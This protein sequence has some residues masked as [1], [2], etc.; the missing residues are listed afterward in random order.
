MRPLLA[1]LLASASV[2]AD[3]PPFVAA[4]KERQAKAKAFE[5]TLT[6]RKEWTGVTPIGSN[7]RKDFEGIG[8]AKLAVDGER[9]WYQV[10]VPQLTGMGD[11]IVRRRSEVAFDGRWHFMRIQTEV[12][13]GER[14]GQVS[15]MN[16]IHDVSQ[17]LVWDDTLDPLRWAYR[18]VGRDGL[19]STQVPTQ[20]AFP[21][22]AEVAATGREERIDGRRC[23]EVSRTFYRDSG[24]LGRENP[25]WLDAERG[26][27][28]KRVRHVTIDTTPHPVLVWTPCR[29]TTSASTLPRFEP[30]ATVT[31]DAFELRESIP[32]ERFVIRFPMGSRVTRVNENRTEELIVAEDGS[33]VP[34][35][36][37]L[38]A[39]EP[40][41]RS[42]QHSLWVVGGV[43][44]VFVALVV[45]LK[46]LARNRID[47][48][49]DSGDSP[50]LLT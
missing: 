18:A 44:A 14:T 4:A 13:N 38:P 21:T 9:F 19:F 40:P 6:V 48:S 29:W 32:D 49:P 45:L 23:V 24:I 42:L 3:D 39:P 31:V 47:D 25:F 20:F 36:K 5:V 26:Y 16:S 17:Q 7:E 11:R 37:Q 50:R 43:V 1:L 41:T 15:Y 46:R 28:P 12:V 2:A 10:D 27:L 34:E 8:T 30:T 22:W 35:G 33:L